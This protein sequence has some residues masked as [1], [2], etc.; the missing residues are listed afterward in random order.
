MNS[1]TRHKGI[2]EIIG[3]EKSSINGNPRYLVRLDGYTC[4]TKVDSSLGYSIT[5]YD[6]KM[7][8]AEVGSHYGTVIIQNVK[9]VKNDDNS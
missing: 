1:I 2:L 5:N 3:R 4:K 8:T 6:G 9:E 7:V